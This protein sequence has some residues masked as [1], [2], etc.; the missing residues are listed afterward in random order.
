MIWQKLYSKSFKSRYV[1]HL[2]DS[3]LIIARSSNALGAG[4][5]KIITVWNY[6]WRGIAYLKIKSAYLVDTYKTFT[7][8]DCK[9]LNIF[10]SLPSFSASTALGASFGKRKWSQCTEVRFANFLSRGFTTMAAINPL[11]RK[12]SK[13][14]SV[15]FVMQSKS[16][17]I[18]YIGQL[19]FSLR[20]KWINK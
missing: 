1:R 6:F 14:T 16:Y 15:Q 13:H 19:L 4:S 8:D 12:P 11:E 18:Q 7:L 9:K 10:I 3:H 5:S 17:K 20:W 2:M